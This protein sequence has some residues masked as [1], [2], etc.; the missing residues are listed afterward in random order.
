MR[1]EVSISE[2]VPLFRE[3]LSK[4]GSVKFSPKGKSMLPMLSDTGD[5]VILVKKN[6]YKKYDVVLY[7]RRYDDS[8]VLHRIVRVRKDGSFTLCG[9]NML[10]REQG[11]AQGDIIG[12]VSRFSHNGVERSADELSYKFYS[13]SLLLKKQLHW[14]TAKAV[15]TFRG[16]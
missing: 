12:A 13:R 6:N 2:L 10:L 15:R 16:K 4:G 9:D 14:I 5:E 1:K 11:I 3:I 8:Y 7:H